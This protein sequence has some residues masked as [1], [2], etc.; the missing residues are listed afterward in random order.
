MNILKSQEPFEV[1]FV[2]WKCFMWKKIFS[3]F[4]TL[5]SELEQFFAHKCLS[6]SL[7]EDSKSQYYKLNIKN[8]IFNNIIVINIYS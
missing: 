2:W 3:I 4:C 8:V 6:S 7:K 5:T 1:K